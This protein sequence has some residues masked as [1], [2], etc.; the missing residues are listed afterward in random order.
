MQAL[1]NLAVGIAAATISCA[2]HAQTLGV[3]TTPPGSFSNSISSAIAKVLVEKAGLQARVQPQASS[4][5]VTVAAG[6]G[7]FS[8]VNTFDAKFIVTGTGEYESEGAKP[9]LRL[10]ANIVPLL[11]GFYTRRDSQIRTIHDVK[12]RRVAGGFTAQKTLERIMRAHLANGGFT[13]DD[14]NPVLAPNVVAAA[15]DFGAGKSDAFIFAFGA[16]KVKEVSAKVGGLRVIS[17]DPAPAA[18][19]RAEKI[20]PGGYTV[21]VKPGPNVEG[22]ESETQVLAFDFILCTNSKVA[23]DVVYKATKAVHENKAMLAATFAPLRGFDPAMMA[24]AYP[25]PLAYHPGAVRFYREAGT[26]PPKR[27]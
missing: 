16:A 12:G 24:R 1:R 20:M 5:G 4:P 10:I 6:T 18:L 13:F 26:W 3:I 27:Q 19:A 25:E 14:V 11:N 7:D 15:N 2:A 23:E 21:A 8:M 17:M 9:D 22:V